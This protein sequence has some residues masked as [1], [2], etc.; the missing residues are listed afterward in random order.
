MKSVFQCFCT[1]C[2]CMH[3]S[4]R[5][6]LP[7]H[8][9]QCAAIASEGFRGMVSS[10]LTGPQGKPKNIFRNFNLIKLAKAG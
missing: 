7:L 5:V 10:F 2:L 9:T 8:H 3:A 4:K 6:G 1:L